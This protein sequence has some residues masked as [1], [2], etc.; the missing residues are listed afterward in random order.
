MNRD[1]SLLATPVVPGVHGT[2]SY[3][4]SKACLRGKRKNWPARPSN[5]PL[6]ET[7][8]LCVCVWTRR[9]ARKNQR[10]GESLAEEQARFNAAWTADGTDIAAVIVGEA[11]RSHPAPRARANHPSWNDFASG[12]TNT[13]YA[14]RSGPIQRNE[15]MKSS[16][17]EPLAEPSQERSGSAMGVIQHAQLPQN[18]RRN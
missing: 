16:E 13:A 6:T 3:L 5:S 18:V 1:S 14:S 9:A 2:N 15:T 4:Q 7:L 12:E 11:N 17:S 10:P 8:R